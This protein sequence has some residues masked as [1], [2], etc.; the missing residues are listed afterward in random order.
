MQ[1]MQRQLTLVAERRGPPGPRAAD[2]L[3]QEDAE[4]VDVTLLGAAAVR[5]GHALA[6]AQQLGGAPQAAAQLP[7]RA[8]GL[9]LPAWER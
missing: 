8:V 1:R 7:A 4:G 5:H 6:L 3:V 9:H 2:D